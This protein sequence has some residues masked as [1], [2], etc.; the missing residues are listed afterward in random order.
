MYFEADSTEGWRQSLHED[1]W[2]QLVQ[3]R[4]GDIP[5]GFNKTERL[6]RVT[7]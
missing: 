7:Q 4:K 3:N 5:P 6:A 2:I 1:I